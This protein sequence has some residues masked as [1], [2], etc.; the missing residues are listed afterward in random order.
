MKRTQ[1]YLEENQYN[2]LVRESEKKGIGVAEYIRELID[3]VM[4][5][6]EEWENHP[7]WNIGEDK[8][9]TGERT[10]SVEHDRIIYKVKKPI[11]KRRNARP[12]SL[13]FR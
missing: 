7:F 4:P 5:K 11:G 8:F 12:S 3:E 2:F 10:G 13:H 6:Q 1:I 9:S